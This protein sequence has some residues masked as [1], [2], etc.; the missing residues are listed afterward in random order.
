MC[1][2]VFTRLMIS[3]LNGLDLQ[4]LRTL[5]TKQVTHAILGHL[6]EYVTSLEN[7][8]FLEPKETLQ[9]HDAVQVWSLT[10]SLDT[11]F[12]VCKFFH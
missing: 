9:L 4:V 7:S 3:L 11:T 5:K 2:L 8:G 10:L 6:T 1:A 12:I